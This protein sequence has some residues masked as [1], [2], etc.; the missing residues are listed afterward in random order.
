MVDRA[1]NVARDLVDRLDVAAITFGRSR[2]EQTPLVSSDQ[3]ADA[4]GVDRH[5]GARRP[6]EFARRPLFDALLRRAPFREPLGEA[7]VEHGDGVVPHPPEQPPQTAGEHARV[8]V[9][10]DDLDAVADAQTA[11]RRGERLRIRQR[12]AAGVSGLWTGEVLPETR[13]DRA[14][15]MALR[16][17]A[18]APTR[19]VEHGAA[20]DD[21]ERWIGQMRGERRRIDQGRQRHVRHDITSLC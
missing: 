6:T 3:L 7:A 10:D 8:L 13:E 15:D 20:V 5:V 19:I 4:S 9:V 14:P 18:R 16:V 11:E 2:V 1:G 12:V 17:L 21:R